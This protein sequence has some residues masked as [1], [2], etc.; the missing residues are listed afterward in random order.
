[1]KGRNLN[2]RPVTFRYNQATASGEHPVQ[3][4]L[5]AEEVAKVFPDLVQYD[6]EGKP[7]TV[8]YHLLTPMLLNQLQ[9]EHKGN[10]ALNEKLNGVLAENVAMKAALNKQALELA[11]MKQAQA[12]QQKLLTKLVAYVQT[13]KPKAAP[14]KVALVQH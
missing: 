6:K 12:E 2:V 4:G 10:T 11:A 3:Y 9:K 8:Y 5:I 1:M 14:Q 13:T 7:F